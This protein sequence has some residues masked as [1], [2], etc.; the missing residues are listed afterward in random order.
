M[1]VQKKLKVKITKRVSNSRKT[2]ATPGA[3]E[4]G[5]LL[6]FSTSIVAKHQKIEG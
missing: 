1:K 4:G 2:Q 3:L 6:H 5:I